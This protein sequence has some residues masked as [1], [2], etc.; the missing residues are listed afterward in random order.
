[1]KISFAETKPQVTITFPF[2]PPV[3]L[4][5]RTHYNFWYKELGSVYIELLA[6]GMQKMSKALQV[7]NG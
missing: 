1:M 4:S 5:L 2:G 3:K 7:G 6:I